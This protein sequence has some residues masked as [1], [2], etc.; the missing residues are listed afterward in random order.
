MKPKTSR[1]TASKPTDDTPQRKG[2]TILSREKAEAV[3][4]PV[5]S[6]VAALIRSQHEPEIPGSIERLKLWLMRME[7]GSREDDRTP[8]YQRSPRS[9]VKALLNDRIDKFVTSSTS[10]RAVFEPYVRSWTEVE[11]DQSEN[12]GPQSQFLPWTADGPLKL[13]AV[14]TDKRVKSGL[15]NRALHQA[16][17]WVSKLLPFGSIHAISVDEAIRGMGGNAKFALDTTTNAGYPSWVRDWYIKSDAKRTV[18]R[19]ETV[20]Y[21]SAR[22]RA[23]CETAK[24]S[25]S[26]KDVVTDFVG[27]ASQRT[28]Q[29]G[30]E[31]LKPKDG[32]LKGKR[33]V[34]AMPKMETIAG[35]TIMAPLQAALTRVRNPKTGVRLIPA[36]APQPVLDKNIQLFLDYAHAKRRLPLSGDISAF[37]AS[38]P[39]WFMWLLS[40]AMSKW[41]DKPTANL[42][43]GIMNSDI[44]HTWV[45]SP[46]AVVEPGPSSVKSGSIFTSLIGCMANATIQKYGEYAGYYSIDQQCV[47][48]DDFILDGNGV[49]PESIEAAFADFGMECN[50]SKQFVEPDMV[51]FLQRLHVLGLPGG[52]G[53][54]MRVGGSTLS[55]EDDTQL[56]WD[57]RNRYA[58]IFQALARIE[59]ANFSPMYES[60]VDF[61]AQGD[62][63]YHLGKEM[64]VSEIV[65]GAGSYAE[66]KLAESALKPWKATGTGVPFS[67]W[68][69]NRVLRGEALPPPGKA[70]FRAVYGVDYDSLRV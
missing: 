27:T 64:T 6:Q 48:G 19:V 21:V 18:A 4:E 62:E 36:W 60:F 37:D 66:R 59:N 38:L 68:T 53:S 50:A 39:P 46:S 31:P 69:V 61:E 28:V 40:V 15:N 70:R 26:Y 63:R 34:I 23:L 22:A 16:L 67:Q 43:L 24:T 9:S 3:V 1:T 35:K 8:I 57:E 25:S 11:Q 47:M 44:Y 52:I 29:K 54:V 41:M 33:L 13:A 42:F 14:M 56:K 12:W 45:I 58:F 65:R 55:V 49:E 51:H 20:E 5:L 7:Q 2:G 10:T 32:K 17:D 30:P